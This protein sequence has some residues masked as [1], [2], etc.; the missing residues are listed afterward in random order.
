MPEVAEP[1]PVKRGPGRPRK[2]VA[3]KI[4][5]PPDAWKTPEPAAPPLD[6][7]DQARIGQTVN[8][9]ATDIGYDD[10][11]RYLCKD[12]KIVERIA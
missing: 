10:G 7:L 6:D 4:E 12:G 11:R 1:Q 5:T 3:P 9:T 2:V 8:E